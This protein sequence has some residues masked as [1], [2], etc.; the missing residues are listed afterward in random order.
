M[1]KP[2]VL[3]VLAAI[4]WPALSLAE[5][6]VT[7]VTVRPPIEYTASSLRD[8]FQDEI[9]RREEKPVVKAENVLPKSES[10]VKMEVQ[11]L[12]WGGNFPQAIINNRIYKVGDFID[13]ARI[14]AINKNGVTL[15][16]FGE[17]IELPVSKS[18]LKNE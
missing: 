2:Y 18:G 15:N 1:K 9:P 11:G 17:K 3:I 10:L 16:L 6:T 14:S 5:N 8:P 13:R 4:F 12:I 7:N